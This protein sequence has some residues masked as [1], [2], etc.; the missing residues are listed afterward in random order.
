MKTEQKNHVVE[1]LR[2]DFSASEACFLVGVQGLSDAQL[3][4]LRKNL[5]N[6]AKIHVAKNTLSK[7]A[8]RDMEGVKELSPFFKNQIAVVFVKQEVPTVAKELHTLSKE[9]EKFTLLAG[10]FDNQVI[11]QNTIKHIA[12]IPSKEVL[13]ARLCGLLKFPAARLAYVLNEVVKQKQA[14]QS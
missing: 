6:K 13:I 3:K 4:K 14:Q 10:Y 1:S 2:N 5:T 11:D 8:I 12:T 9:N 7:I